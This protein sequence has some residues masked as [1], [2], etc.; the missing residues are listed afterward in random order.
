MD[1]CACFYGHVCSVHLILGGVEML[2][3]CLR[4]PLAKVITRASQ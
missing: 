3:N 1:A 4:T 2:I